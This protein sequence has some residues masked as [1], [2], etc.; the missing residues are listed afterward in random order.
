MLLSAENRVM[1]NPSAGALL[2]NSAMAQHIEGS[3]TVVDYSA[4]AERIEGSDIVADHDSAIA[5]YIDKSDAGVD[6]SAMNESIHRTDAIVDN[7]AMAERIDRTDAVTDHGDSV[8]DESIDRT[9]AGV[10]SSVV[11][12]CIDGTDAVADHADSAMDESIDRTDAGVGNSAMDE[13]GDALQ[14]ALRLLQESTDRKTGSSQLAL[15]TL[16]KYV[17]NVHAQPNDL[18]FRKINMAN[19]QFTARVGK[20]N[21]GIDVLLAA[22]FAH[23]TSSQIL[24]LNR[25]DPALLWIAESL[26]NDALQESDQSHAPL[27][28]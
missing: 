20:F 24:E 5:E 16:H 9:D 6:N 25:D 21:G 23:D 15:R 10:H 26:I 22:G 17:H 12:D 28:N 7:S 14:A 8:M 13:R 18:K 4:M 11:D 2:D 3:G 27:S 1:V 19:P